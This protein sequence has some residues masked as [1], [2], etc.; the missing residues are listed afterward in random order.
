MSRF[1]ARNTRNTNLVDAAAKVPERCKALPDGDVKEEMKTYVLPIE[2]AVTRAVAF[3]LATN[4]TDSAWQRAQKERDARDG[5]ADHA[6]RT[7]QL[8]LVTWGHAEGDESA[9]R[10]ILPHGMRPFVDYADD[11]PGQMIVVLESIASSANPVLTPERKAELD[12][13]IR[14][15]VGPLDDAARAARLAWLR[16]SA[17]LAR[18]ENAADDVWRIA[19]KAY[20]IAG[21]HLPADVVEF[22]FAPMLVDAATTPPPAEP[23]STP[24][25]T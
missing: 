17:A 19:R 6:L 20:R 22:V 7:A 21:V 9:A 8:R 24:Q 15:T 23:T 4:E 25:T 10:E 1:I 18:F 2:A 14:P 3:G 11:Q 13:L 12:A 16:R 5:T